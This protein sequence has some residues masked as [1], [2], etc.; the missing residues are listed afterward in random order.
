MSSD[1]AGRVEREDHL[2]GDFL[3]I[4]LK[5]GRGNRRR[6]HVKNAI[7]FTFILLKLTV[8]YCCVNHRYSQLN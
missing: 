2:N 3:E 4:M 7:N 8:I 1:K 6:C 5:Y